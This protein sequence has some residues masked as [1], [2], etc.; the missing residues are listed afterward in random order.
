ML[1]QFK[2]FPLQCLLEDEQEYLILV[3]VPVVIF[4][5]VAFAA[6]LNWPPE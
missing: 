4:V 6:G 3:T 5:S 2:K 1:A